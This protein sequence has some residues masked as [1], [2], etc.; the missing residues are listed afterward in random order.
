MRIGIVN[1]GDELLS[2]KILNSNQF[3]LSRMLAPLG[4]EI[5]F[6][7]VIGD[8][9]RAVAGALEWAAGGRAGERGEP[10]VDVLVL[11]G[12]LGPTR[13]DLTR[14]AVASFLRR[15]V[16][17]DP[18]A[19]AWLCAFLGKTAPD[20]PAGQRIQA[21]VPEGTEPLRNPVG[22]ACG[23]RFSSHGMRVYVFPG[24]PSELKAMAG[25]YLLPELPQDRV[26][27]EKSLWTFGWSESSQGQAFSGLDLGEPF[28]FSSLPDEKGVRLSLSCLVTAADRENRA[29]E[30][31]ALWGKV[32][33][34]IPGEA[35][36][37]ADGA[38]LTEAVQKL[39]SARKATVSVA[40][41]CTGGGLGALLTDLPGS[42]EVFQKGFLT[43]SNQAKTDLLGV[44]P[45]ILKTHGAVSE[46]TALAMVR[47]CLARSGADYGCAITGIAGPGGGTPEKPVGTVWISVG[48]RNAALARRFQFRGH[49]AAV[50]SRS[51]HTALNLLRLLISEKLK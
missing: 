2:G 17:E 24:V 35:V 8:D 4:H 1:I 36:I 18:N 48:T 34:A 30:L 22:T 51:C 7:I 25:L 26:L 5:P 11:T 14:E 3:D 12:G 39:L 42:S 16:A 40:E 32:V 33:Q 41:S 20:L 10:R 45:E 23:F 15:K 43:Y 21:G 46:A 6:G 13:D 47:G 37:D 19:L 9:A 49:R 50:R 44:D 29:A 28:R 31:E 38:S 27:L